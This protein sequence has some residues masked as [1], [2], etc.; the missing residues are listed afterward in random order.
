MNYRIETRGFPEAI[1]MLTGARQNFADMNAKTAFRVG[2]RA[3]RTIQREFRSAKNNPTDTATARRT[4]TLVRSYDQ[5]VEKL[6]TGSVQLDVGLVRPG[7]DREVLEYA[8]VHE[9]EGST[10]IRAKKGG[11]LTIPLAAAKTA[12][13]VARGTA[14]DFD[15]TFFIRSKKG[16]LLLMQRQG[17]ES[18]PLFVLKKSVTVPGR[19]ALV[20]VA[21]RDIIPELN[22]GVSRNFENILKPGAGAA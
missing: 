22:E 21:R 9:T 14:R 1:R 6:P 4:G 19:P 17:T 16:N 3:V 11:F 13:G 20:P 15:N 5:L 10:T 2:T 7:V 18:V 12:A 8:R